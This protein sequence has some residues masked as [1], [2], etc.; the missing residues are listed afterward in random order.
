MIRSITP[1]NIESVKG[2]LLGSGGVDVTGGMYG[3]IM[4][5]MK[6]AE[7]GIPSQVFNAEKPGNITSFL[8]NKLTEG[9]FIRGE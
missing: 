6:L 1:A 3:K 5:L 7:A 8:K 2:A 4:E 9:T